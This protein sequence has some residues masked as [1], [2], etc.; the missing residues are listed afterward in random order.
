MTESTDR[1]DENDFAVLGAGI[2]GS[3]IACA[4]ALAGANVTVLSRSAEKARA[5]TDEILT[6]ARQW[7]LSDEGGIGVAHERLRFVVSPDDVPATVG[8]VLE[9]LPESLPLKV[10]VLGQVLDRLGAGVVVATNTSSLSVRAIGR[11]VGREASTVGLHFMNP[12][13][14]MPLVEVVTTSEAA[15]AA[16][17]RCLRIAARLGKRVISVAADSPGFVWNRLQIALLREAVQLVTDGLASPGDVDAAVELGLARRW[18]YAGPLVTARL[19]GAETFRVV[20]RNLLPLCSQR[21]ELDDLEAHLPS[22]ESAA[23]VGAFREQGL[24]QLLVGGAARG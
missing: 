14:L 11:G 20:A 15:P 22:T 3:S 7:G 9:S 10:D 19:G 13:L 4:L 5:R 8:A 16:V 18:Q 2:M 1:Y 23:A 24:A 12:A 6:K 21:S 17:D